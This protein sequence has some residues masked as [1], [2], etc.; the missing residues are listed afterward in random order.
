MI[1]N[2]TL[3]QLFMEPKVS[4]LPT[5]VINQLIPTLQQIRDKLRETP[6]VRYWILLIYG[7]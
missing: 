1:I 3:A 7:G 4:K 5:Q 2:I 6:E